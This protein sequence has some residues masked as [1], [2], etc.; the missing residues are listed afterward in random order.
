MNQRAKDLSHRI[1]SFGDEVIT[2]VENLSDEDWAKTSPWE[3]WPVGVAA[4][5]LG[6]GHFT[7][8]KAAGMIIRGEQLPQMTMDQVNAM[9]DKDAREHM[10]CTK[11]EALD[12]LRKNSAEMVAFVTGLSDAELDRK[13]SMPAFGGEVT[14]EQLLDY[15]LL[16]SGRRHLDSMQK[17]V[18]GP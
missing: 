3:Q 1:K 16:Q 18:A 2:F 5:H 15:V 8:H 10:D 7:I 13:T 12:H 17:A 9:S 4:R 6:A 14:T 11:A